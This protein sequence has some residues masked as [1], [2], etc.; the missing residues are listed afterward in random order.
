MEENWMIVT[1]LS[2]TVCNGYPSD[3][4]SPNRKDHSHYFDLFHRGDGVST[5][6]FS[7]YNVNHQWKDLLTNEIIVLQAILVCPAVYSYSLLCICAD[8]DRTQLGC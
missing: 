3:L 1:S 4:M 6:Y 2:M 8:A 5:M 7:H